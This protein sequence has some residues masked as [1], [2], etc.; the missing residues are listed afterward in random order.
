MSKLF[1]TWKRGMDQGAGPAVGL[2]II[3]CIAVMVLGVTASLGVCALFGLELN[4]TSSNVS[5]AIVGTLT[6]V[7]VPLLL[8]WMCDD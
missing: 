2:A 1:K 3:L 4:E 8:G 7:V 5:A 6:V